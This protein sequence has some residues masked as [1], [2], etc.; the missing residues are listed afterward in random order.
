M[1]Y[2]VYFDEK[3]EANCNGMATTWYYDNSKRLNEFFET[4]VIADLIEKGD[5]KRDKYFGVFSHDCMDNIN[6]REDGLSNRENFAANLDTIINKY[7]CDVY[8][9]QKRRK[10]NN[11]ATQAENYHPGI[12]SMFDK[13]LDSMGLK[14]PHRLDKIVLFNLMVGKTEFWERYYFDFLKPAM[15]CMR[16]MPECYGDSNYHNLGRPMTPEK[17]ERFMKAFGQPHYPYHP[18]ICERLP[19]IYLQYH[20]E[21]SFKQIF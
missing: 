12:T 9:F 4:G 7:D 16:N 5:H 1:I 6:F 19:S 11:M 8:S 18:F 14:M 13:I 15:E 3:S 17:T 21:F 20:N 2:Q 10:Q